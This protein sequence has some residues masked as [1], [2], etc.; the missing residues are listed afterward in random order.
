MPTHKVIHICKPHEPMHKP[1]LAKEYA[2]STPP[3]VRQ[4]N[5]REERRTVNKGFAKKRVSW[6][7]EHSTSHQLSLC[8][9]SL[10]HG[11]SPLRIAPKH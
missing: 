9:D 11:N 3:A 5:G 4:T 10:E 2:F 6:L 8:I 7:I 1:K